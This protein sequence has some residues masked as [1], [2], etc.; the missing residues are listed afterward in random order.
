MHQLGDSPFGSVQQDTP[1][2]GFGCKDDFLLQNQI[3]QC[4]QVLV[5]DIY[6]L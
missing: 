6:P 2:V 5:L 3:E 4:S 1:K